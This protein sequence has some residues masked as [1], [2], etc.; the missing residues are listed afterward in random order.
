MQGTHL[1][2]MVSDVCTK[3]FEKMESETEPFTSKDYTNKLVIHMLYTMCFGK[4]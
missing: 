1:E 4:E 3:M 2:D